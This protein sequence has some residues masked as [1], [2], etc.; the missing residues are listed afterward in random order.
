MKLDERKPEEIEQQ[1]TSPVNR[2]DRP[3]VEQIE[4]VS[5]WRDAWR[6]LRKN[7]FAMAGMIIILFFLIL[8]LIA[9]LLTSYSYYE[10]NL[11]NR[12]LPPSGEHWMGTDDLGRDILTRI[13]YGARVSLQVGFF[14]VIGAL[15]FGTFLGIIAGY[16]GRWVDMI[17]SRIFDILLAFPSILLA[18]AIVAILGASLQNALIAIAIINIPIFGRIVRS[19]VISLRAEEYIM[20]AKAQG[21]KNGRIIFHHILPNSITPIIV[22]ATLGFGTAILEA[23]ALGFLGLGAQPPTP[24]WGQML[25][26]SREFIQLAP[27]TLIMPGVS[28]M[29]V[30]LG[31][32]LV[33]DGLRDVLDPKMRN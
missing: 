12:L 27:W 20:A 32:N 23:A 24:E 16:F 18:I 1:I 26:S 28:I 25:A 15:V 13:A 10:Q 19:R 33:G 14:A 4:T 6:R 22:Q 30:V 29:L 5:P 17:I 21:M 3:D 8:A 7:R 31:F 11:A 2:D 9:P